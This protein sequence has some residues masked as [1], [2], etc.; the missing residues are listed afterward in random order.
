MVMV[1]VW[2]TAVAHLLKGHL[3]HFKFIK[4]VMEF[5]LI[6]SYHSHTETTLNYLQVALSGISSNIHLFLPYR[7]SH[8]MSKIL[9]IHSL[10]HFIE[11]IRKMGSADISDTEISEATHKH[12]I[13]D[14]YCSSN[15]V[16]Y[17]PQMLC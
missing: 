13:K 4:S 17:I 12:L 9:K 15:K 8:S 1:K 16:N 5:I 3:D 11:C 14:G 2:V 7:K 10:L 6:A